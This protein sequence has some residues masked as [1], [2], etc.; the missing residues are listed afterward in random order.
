MHMLRRLSRLTFP[1]RRRIST[2]ANAAPETWATIAE[3]SPLSPSTSA[4]ELELESSLTFEPGQWV[5]LYI[6][7][8]DQVGGY[9]IT[10]LP[11]E[12]P[13]LSLA[14]KAS[15]HPPAAWCTRD[16]RAGDRVALRVGGSFVLRDTPAALYVAG[17]VGINP[18]YS[19]LRAHCDRAPPRRAALLYTAQRHDE[20][21]FTAQLSRLA[22]RLPGH[23]RFRLGATREPSSAAA[24]PL[25]GAGRLDGRI[26]DA[27]L[28][29]ALRWL[30]CEPNEVREG[31]AVPWMAESV[32]REPGTASEACA[33]GVC[34]YVCGP[35][36]MTD[37]ICATLRRMGVGQVH[38]ERW[39]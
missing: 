5:D 38:A 28:E 9:S 12:L 7:A 17:G 14:V 24:P 11:A 16:A 3:V 39:W 23:T 25:P 13:R 19:M 32:A 27:A 26:G 21:L 35:P 10:S 2:H 33:E 34:A 31:S 15:A 37:E 22:Q 8:I 18:L 6:P 4:L 1:V 29:E 30:G 36:R 20:L